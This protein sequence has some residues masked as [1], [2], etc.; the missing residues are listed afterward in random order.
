MAVRAY[1]PSTPSRPFYISRSKF[2]AVWREAAR[3]LGQAFCGDEGLV[4][5]DFHTSLMDWIL[6][7]RS[8]LGMPDY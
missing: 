3:D 7:A 5:V 8:G 6:G 4:M 2:R 1:G